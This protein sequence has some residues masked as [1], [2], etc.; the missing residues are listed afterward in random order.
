MDNLKKSA[1]GNLLKN[2]AGDLVKGCEFTAGDSCSNCIATGTPAQYD[3]VVGDVN[4]IC[5]GVCIA[6]TSG[7]C[8]VSGAP[9]PAGAYVLTQDANP[10]HWYYIQNGYSLGT[11]SKWNISVLCAGAADDIWS[12]DEMF[13]WLT[14]SN[15]QTWNLQ[16]R[17]R[18]AATGKYVLMFWNHHH[19]GS[20]A[21]VP[22]DD[23]RETTL[24]SDLDTCEN[25]G[26]I[27]SPW[28]AL[29][30]SATITPI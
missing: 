4:S 13:I 9:S 7:S 28:V 17:Y 16:I 14:K 10:C 24:T 27:D 12:L 8:K 3:I 15:T 18:S 6:M 2:A 1:G 30:G 21:D 11:L 23:C 19:G 22:I 5:N 20:P 26:T 25:G 29:G